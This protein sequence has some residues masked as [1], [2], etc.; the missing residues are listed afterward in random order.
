MYCELFSCLVDVKV[1]M[2]KKN[3]RVCLVVVE[4]RFVGCYLSGGPSSVYG[5]GCPSCFGCFVE[6]S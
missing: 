5:E 2:E 6:V 3:V 4:V 1:V